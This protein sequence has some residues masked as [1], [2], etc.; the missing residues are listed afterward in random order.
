MEHAEEQDSWRRAVGNIFNCFDRKKAQQLH[1]DVL[2]MS[3]DLK[4]ALLL[5][6]LK[7]EVKSLHKLLNS[8]P[9]RAPL[10]SQ[11]TILRYNE[12]V[13]LGNFPQITSQVL[14]DTIAMVDVTTTVPTVMEDETTAVMC[15]EV[16]EW[17]EKTTFKL[18]GCNKESCAVI[19]APISPTLNPC[20]V[21]GWL[22]GYPVVYWFDEER[23]YQ[24]GMVELVR[25]VVTATNQAHS[26]SPATQLLW[27]N[28]SME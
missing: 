25:N 3:H 5:D 18:Q 10:K 23:G 16:S 24:L 22:L 9:I 7:P 11:W 13:F 21:Y 4:P 8:V 1:D 27:Q 12:E 19:E 2:C 14:N 17:L 28:V 20:T 26:V 15:R 6:Y